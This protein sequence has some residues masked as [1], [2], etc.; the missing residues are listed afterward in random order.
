[1]HNHEPADYRCPFCRNLN[2]DADLPLEIIHRDEDVFVKVNPGWWTN[3]PGSV[4]VVPVQH[5]ENVFD[6]PPELGPIYLGL[7]AR[8]IETMRPLVLTVDELVS[9]LP[10]S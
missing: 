1:M 4:L 6:L 2:G 8:R 9:A 10:A 5:H 7:R 3:N